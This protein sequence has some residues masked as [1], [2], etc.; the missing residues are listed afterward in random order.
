MKLWLVVMGL[1]GLHRLA[2]LLAYRDQ[3]AASTAWSDAIGPLLQG[4]RFDAKVA[5]S[6]IAVPLVASVACGFLHAE[7]IARRVRL[8]VGSAALV[9]SAALCVVSF[10]YFGEFRE[11]VGPFALELFYDDAHAI[12]RTVWKHYHPLLG[13]AAFGG[14]AAVLVGG[15]VRL[16]RQESLSEARARALGATP[17]RAVVV[18]ALAV[19]LLVAAARG[20]LGS[21]PLEDRDAAVSRDDFLNAVVP[22][23]HIALY[24]AAKKAWRMAGGAALEVYLPDGDVHGALRRLTGPSDADTVAAHLARR[25]A[26]TAMP[27]R[28]VVLIVMES[29]EQWPMTPEYAGLGIADGLKGLAARGLWFNRFVPASDGT[30][31]SL[32]AMVT[33]LPD[34]DVHTAH[35]PNSRRPYPTSL[36]ATFARLG[37]RTRLFYGGWLSWQRLEEFARAQGFTEVYGAAHMGGWSAANE[38]GVPDATLFDF[39]LA[40]LDD[41]R[42]TFDLVLTTSFHPPYD[43][44]VRALGFPLAAVPPEV[45]ARCTSEPDLVALGHFWYADRAMADFVAR[46]ERVLRSALFAVT[47][48]HAGRRTIVAHPTFEEKH[49]VPLVLYGP[50]VLGGR[51]MPP[52]AAGSHVDIPAT[53]IELAAPTG[54]VYHALGRNLLAPSIRPWGFGHGVAVGRDFVA[55]LARGHV[56]RAPGAT[57]GARLPALAELKR[58]ANDANGVAW[59]MIKADPR[60]RL[61]S[62]SE[63]RM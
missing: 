12:V 53:L 2:L 38:W 17:G 27:A 44:D 8:W 10:V 41:A 25:A 13:I 22:N 20:S 28:H 21:R 31:S 18:L 34:A 32:A 24:Y 58:A 61:G 56:R 19:T 5:T 4:T 42:P 37:F 15:F 23:P 55:D 7:R 45:R 57:P 59:W 62:R 43:L 33:G 46:A 6:A 49:L 16:L 26:G 3:A 1:L 48:D 36:P 40:Q 63:A 29:Y 54:F 50:D 47:G 60:L 39:V 51:A 52:D 35:Q 14:I 11:P 30:M 9:L